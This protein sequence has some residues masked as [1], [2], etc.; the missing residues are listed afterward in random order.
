MQLENCN[1]HVS[2][3]RR[4]ERTLVRG[5]EGDDLR[6]E[7]SESAVYTLS[8]KVDIAGY[9]LLEGLFR[10]GQP[11]FVD[12]FL[13]REMLVAVQE[14]D[15]DSDTQI[16]VFSVSR[17]CG[18][19]SMESEDRDLLA[20]LR[21]FDVLLGAGIGLESVLINLA[22]GGYGAIS[23]DMERIMKGVNDGRRL[24]DELTRAAT[25]TKS[26]GYKRLLTTLKTN[27]TSNTD[28]IEDLRR[29]ADREEEEC[30]SGL[31]STSRLSKACLLDY[32]LLACLVQ[33]CSRWSL[34][35]PTYSQS[36]S[37]VSPHHRLL[38]QI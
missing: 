38:L 5:G 29:Q 34:S 18:G 26:T 10:S 2:I 27:V 20:A 6:D 1:V 25:R 9:Q 15:Y 4:I 35:C 30:L 3:K 12:P 8:L 19:L 23:T 36:Q 11:S 22:R 37:R 17:G 7:G 16:V 28:L 14:L 33:S 31:R 13:D 32:S 24:E 21:A